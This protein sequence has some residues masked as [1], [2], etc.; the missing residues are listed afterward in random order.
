MGIE[1]DEPG[2]IWIDPSAPQGTVV[3]K[4]RG[5]RTYDGFDILV[6][7]DLNARLMIDLEAAPEK[8]KEENNRPADVPTKSVEIK[9]AD[10]V[11][12]SHTTP[13]LDSTNNRLLVM[14]TPGDR[15]RVNF[16]RNSLVFAPREIFPLE[17]QPHQLG[18]PPGTAI[19]VKAHLVPVHVAS[20][21]K[22]RMWAN[23]FDVVMPNAD[24]V[25]DPKP[26]AMELPA[27]EGV[28][29]LLISAIDSRLTERW[30]KPV[31]ERR[32][33][34]VVVDEKKP[35]SESNMPGMSKLL[36]IDPANPRWYE[37]LTNLPLLP[38]QRRGPL[39]SGDTVRW[40]HPAL[41][42]MIQLGGIRRGRKV[43]TEEV[44]VAWEAYPLPI[45][46]PGQPHILEVEYPNDM[47]QLLGISIIEPN[48]AGAVMPIGLDSGVYIA[49]EEVENS[50]RML[51]H[52][53][54]FW[55]RTKAPLLLVTNRHRRSPA[56]YGKISVLGTSQPQLAVLKL[57]QKPTSHMPLPAVND[58]DRFLKYQAQTKPD[59]NAPSKTS[60]PRGRLLAGY[61]DRPFFIENFSAPESMDLFSRRSLDDWGTF[62]FG[63]QRLVE[64][65]N[66]VGYNGLVMSVLAD[67]STIYP[68]T[69]VE[70]TPQHDTGVFFATGQDPIRKDAL[71]LVFRMF[72]RDGLTLIPAVQFSAPLAELESLLRE[73]PAKAV[74][75]ELVGADGR[76]WIDK[77][78]PNQGLAPFY[79]PLHPRVQ[80]AMLGVVNELVERYGRH[81]SFGGLAIQLSADGYGQLPGADWAYDDNTVERFVKDAR[82]D[83]RDAKALL[84][85]GPER[86]AARDELLGDK[87]KPE[88]LRWRAEQLASLH[89]RMKR[90]VPGELMLLSGTLFESS[91]AQ[92]G[93]K[94][95]LPRRVKSDDVLL[96][97]GLRPQLY[98]KDLGVSLVRPYRIGP[99][100]ADT[101]GG[102]DL[103]LNLSPDVDQLF[104]VAGSNSVMMYHEP[105]RTRLESFDEQSP[106][107]K[108]NTYT[109]LVSQF[110]PSAQHNRR[111]F[112][113]GVAAHDAE[114][115]LDGGWLLPLG[116]E[117]ALADFISTY[118]QLP[119]PKFATLPETS[120]PVIV[121]TLSEA[122]QTYVYFVNDSPW[123]VS[124]E[125]TVD[126]AEQV[127]V[128]RVGPAKKLPPLVRQPGRPATW[129]LD[130]QPY[131]LVAAKFNDANVKLSQPR[132]ILDE[133]VREALAKRISDLSARIAVLANP[134]PL[135]VLAN[136]DFEAPANR[137]QILGW[138][139]NAPA[140]T[141]AEIDDKIVR[142]GKQSLHLNSTGPRLSIRSDAIDVPQTGRLGVSIWL[143]SADPKNQ[144][145]IRLGVE[146]MMNDGSYYRFATV[147][148]AGMNAVA[149]PDNWKAG[150]APFSY[151][152]DDVPTSGITD[153]HLRFD[154]MNAG[155]VWVD[156]IQVFDLAFES[157]ERVELSKLVSLADYKRGAGQ[158]LGCLQLLESYWPQFLV[159]HVPVPPGA[160]G[161]A[162]RLPPRPPIAKP[163]EEEPEKKP[164][165]FDRLKSFVPRFSGD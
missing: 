69:L 55:P 126:A 68:S 34:L 48:A 28:Y 131:D 56:V 16:D 31:A 99:R 59:L 135:P 38:G 142:S 138:G 82:V 81:P 64:Y 127:R 1:A 91:T 95:A 109:W 93:M 94:P 90:I 107:G 115:L 97:F 26:V 103:E 37:R 36:E 153:L 7:A 73:Q 60:A 110:S 113:H 156:D 111:R 6:T 164:G 145:V 4:Q 122:G 74:G 23:E 63:S 100:A 17:I 86:F 118:R 130:L 30:K 106:Y 14:R 157:N 19:R 104:G 154:V 20:V 21:S 136:P 46:D 75:V 152:V 125:I 29:D 83:E 108:S 80:E 140:G 147:G 98:A 92:R 33:Q 96:A 88:W 161:V 42:S 119:A 25:R 62:Y 78:P 53:L 85:T 66:H 123:P 43:K 39:G 41:G 15:L 50:P 129:K 32:V 143:K 116:Q 2:S 151:Q 10:L 89:R 71:E 148:G 114:L 133:A 70:P 160:G 13:H 76:R 52:R 40:E 54:V 61:L 67:G 5:L 117:D 72:D 162:R 9:L 137:R 146:G 163:V 121:R 120:E 24:E 57:G 22:E 65:L 149:I 51:K 58:I 112:A 11:N 18:L 49:D 139:V 128:E 124:L 47:P 144:P 12:E 141:S 8:P 159:E 3:V 27:T 165:V 150:A 105:I 155:D 158:Y 87:L 101:S 77:T 84:V 45:S 134:N 79:N 132:A 102:A 35:K 44:P